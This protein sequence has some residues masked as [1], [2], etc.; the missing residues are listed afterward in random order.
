MFGTQKEF[1]DV[2]G[3][4]STAERYLY[5]LSIVD[6]DVVHKVVHAGFHGNGAFYLVNQMK[7]E[8]DIQG[9]CPPELDKVLLEESP[10]YSMG[11]YAMLD[12]MTDLYRN[13]NDGEAQY[14]MKKVRQRNNWKNSGKLSSLSNA[15]GNDII[16][17][18]MEIFKSLTLPKG[19]QKRSDL[20]EFLGLLSLAH[21]TAKCKEGAQRLLDNFESSVWP[22]DSDMPLPSATEPSVDGSISMLDICLDEAEPGSY[23]SCEGSKPF[24][25]GFSCGLWTLFHTLSVNIPEVSTSLTHPGKV[26]LSGVKAFVRSYF[27]C[28]E[29]RDHFIE[30]TD[31]SPE[32]KKVF[33]KEDAIVWLWWAH[34]RVNLRLS[35]EEARAHQ[36]DPY[37]PK[38]FFPSKE[39]CEACYNTEFGAN[40]RLF[41]YEDNSYN[42]SGLSL[43]HVKGFL[44]RFYMVRHVHSHGNTESEKNVKCNATQ[45]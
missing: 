11:K 35:I 25:R 29:C 45:C 36:G 6:K 37:F 39:K 3:A 24:S 34:N 40:D 8:F 32:F 9:E 1:L 41:D 44:T 26:V 20:K 38:I 28:Q 23:R 4:G 19:P 14:L 22:E 15:D 7:R 43:R 31:K 2:F 16:K 13:Q 10:E 27:S 12:K 17:V 33:S 5:R 42:F 30:M 21:P 18:T